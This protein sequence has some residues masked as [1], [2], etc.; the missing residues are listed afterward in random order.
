MA[1][2]A[3]SIV[4]LLFAANT[5]HVSAV[6]KG[7]INSRMTTPIEPL[8]LAEQGKP[9]VV[10]QTVAGAVSAKLA[11]ACVSGIVATIPSFICSKNNETF[12]LSVKCPKDFTLNEKSCVQ[13]PKGMTFD[14]KDCVLSCPTPLQNGKCFVGK[15]EIPLAKEAPQT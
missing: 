14:G 3:A 8:L 15:S 9:T 12:G 2:L 7:F 4:A 13:C 5:L 6:S 11:N 10:D 1:R